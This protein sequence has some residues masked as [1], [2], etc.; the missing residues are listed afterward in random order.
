[1]VDVTHVDFGW[2][3][4]GGISTTAAQ[5]LFAR[6]VW[7][8]YGCHLWLGLALGLG[9]L[10]CFASQLAISV[11]GWIL[12]S[13]PDSNVVSVLANLRLLIQMAYIG[14]AAFDLII[15]TLLSLRLL[16]SRNGFNPW[17]DSVRGLALSERRLTRLS[18]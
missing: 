14:A 15:C 16:R 3:F 1:M 4:A 10:F 7:R 13:Q 17:T 8:V 2:L 11:R 18:S 12:L 6:R 9:L 5:A